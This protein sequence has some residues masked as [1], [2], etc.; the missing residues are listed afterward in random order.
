VTAPAGCGK[1]HQIVRA[2]STHSTPKRILVLTHT[3]AGV[4]ALRA[5]LKRGNV[6]PSRYALATIDGWAMRLATIF[7]LRSAIEPAVLE[8]TDRAHDYAKIR[9]AASS[10]LSHGKLDDLL[11]A[12]YSRLIVDEYQD[13]TKLQHAVVT[14]LARSLPTCIL[15]DPMQAI[16]GFGGADPLPSWSDVTAFFP[17]FATLETPWRWINADTPNLGRW[18]L[19]VRQRLQSGQPIR[20]DGCPEEVRWVQLDGRNDRQRRYAAALARPPGGEGSVVVIAESSSPESQRLVASQTPG[21][22]TIEAV[23]LKDF[24]EFARAFDVGS[25]QALAQLLEFGQSLMT[26]TGVPQILKRVPILTSN[27]ARKP[28][29]AAE[30]AAIGFL[31]APSHARAAALLATI[32]SQ[33]GVRVHRPIVLNACLS[34]LRACGSGGG[35]FYDQAVRERERYRMS[36]RPIPQRAVGSTLLL[37]GLEAEVVVILDAPRHDAKNLYVA[38]TR[39]SKLLVVCSPTPVLSPR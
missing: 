1:T 13:C 16:F 31:Q 39:G 11:S 2:L 4:A 21:A 30:S 38:M 28:P 33:T 23:D 10:A 14:E 17:V 22:V 24:V 3:N 8:L 5:R 15:G 7:P 25:T 19:D 27:T 6:A 32:R 29:T 26:N 18:L 37:K 20:L 9:A 35:S 12:T 36:G 34:A